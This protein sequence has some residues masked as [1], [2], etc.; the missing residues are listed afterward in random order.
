MEEISLPLPLPRLFETYNEEL[1]EDIRNYLASLNV[2]QQKAYLIGIEHLGS[3]FNIPKS[4]GFI[5][6]KKEQKKH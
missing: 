1:Q 2:L 5:D 3:S 6:W 4:N